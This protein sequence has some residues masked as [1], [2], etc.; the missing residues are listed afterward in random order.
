MR[1]E[2]K[3]LLIAT[4][5]ATVVSAVGAHDAE[6]W[7][8]EALPV[9]LGAAIL[10]ATARR[11]PLTDLAYRLAF[12]HALVLL[13]GAHY[14]YARVPLGSWVQDALGLARNHYDRLGHVMQGFVPALLARE[15]L[16][17]LTPLRPGGWL[18]FLVTC[19]ALAISAAYELFEWLAAVLSA[20]AATDFL[21]TQGD[22]WDT[23]WDMALALAG[24]LAS[25][26][27]LSRAHDRAL[28]RREAYAI[29]SRSASAPRESRP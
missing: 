14:T 6:I 17:R 8:L 12:V 2:R 23:Q 3:F 27:L 15:V 19:V 24:A 10:V 18:F 26:W 4:A 5:I 22:P 25:Q 9:I 20:T 29:M 16:L 11:F 21:S 28:A 1:H 13:L 7:W